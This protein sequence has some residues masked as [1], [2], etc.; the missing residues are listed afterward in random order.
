MLRVRKWLRENVLKAIFLVALAASV[1][2]WLKG[3]F[4][5]TLRYS[6]PSGADI[7]CIGREWIVDHRPFRQHEPTKEVF[8]IL[9]ATFDHDD[10]NRTLTEVVVRAFQGKKGI[11]ATETCRVLKIDG[12][13]IRIEEAAA[14]RGQEWLSRHDADVLVFGEAI[15]K[16]EALNL[17]FL[18]VGGRG[19]FH[20]H[21]FGLKSG[22]LK[23]DFNE[24]VGAQLQAVALATVKPATEESRKYLVETLRSLTGRLEH[25]IRFTPSGLSGGQ[26]AD[27]QFALGL[28]LATI[29]E[30]AGDDMALEDAVA[31]YRAAL[32]ERT[33][34]RVALD[35]AQTQNNLGFA[36]FRLGERESGTAR[37]EEAVAAYR[38][39]LEEFTRADVPL[40][41]AMTQNNLGVALRMLG[42]RESGTAHLEEAV[43][44]Y[45][46]TLQVYTRERAPFNWAMMQHNLG[47]VL[48]MLGS[49]ESGTARLEEA[50]AAERA[51]L[52]EWTREAARYEHDI[53]QQNLAQCLALLEQRR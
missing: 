44:A 53:A 18:P 47:V 36:L 46:A 43:A 17:H 48:R 6:L 25:L 52:E 1:T 14:K 20:Q 22:L 12:A 16:E 28:A 7:S 24:A 31:A 45:R 10:A 23:G 4:E 41:W 40:D 29:G 51:A 42:S 39:A 32:E 26:L 9:V 33:R 38:A 49:R 34:G 15:G 8:R 50:V 3:V 11:E 5:T 19:N 13:G 27:I 21:A 35:W 30:Q 2:A 37:L